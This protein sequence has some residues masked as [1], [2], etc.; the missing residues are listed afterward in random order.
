MATFRRHRR[1]RKSGIK[2]ELKEARFKNVNWIHV[3]ENTIHRPAPVH[4]MITFGF[5]ES[6]DIF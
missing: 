1:R 2:K 3:E 6:R 4:V 5:Y